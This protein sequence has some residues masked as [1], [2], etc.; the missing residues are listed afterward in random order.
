MI[1]A[2]EQ[3]VENRVKEV[4]RNIEKKFNA[5]KDMLQEGRIHREKVETLLSSL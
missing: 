1:K 3:I 2:T 5:A 4:G